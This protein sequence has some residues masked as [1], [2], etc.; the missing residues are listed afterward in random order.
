MN[1]CAADEERMDFFVLKHGASV[2]AGRGINQEALVRSYRKARY[3]FLRDREQRERS[4]KGK[5][6]DRVLVFCFVG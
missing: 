1:Y 3:S 4:E 6:P 5:F 2:R